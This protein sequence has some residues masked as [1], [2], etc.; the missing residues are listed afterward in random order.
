M[1]GKIGVMADSS[2]D[3]PVG[4]AKKK[5]INLVPNSIFINKQ[6]PKL[7]GVDIENKE[8]LEYLRQKDDVTTEA[9]V[10]PR[11]CLMFQTLLKKYEYLYSFNV[12]DDLSKCYENAQYGLNLYKQISLDGDTENKIKLIDTRAVGISF[13]IIVNRI[14]TIVNVKQDMEIARL[15]KYIAW[16]VKN[17]HMYFVVDDL[18]WLKRSGKLNMISG[19]LGQLLDFKPVI[20]LEKGMLLP[21]EKCRGK[22]IAVDG[23]IKFIKEAASKYKRG[24]EIW[25]GHSAAI[26]D[27]KYAVKQLAA[28]LK[29][30]KKKILLVDIGPTMAAHIGPGGVCVTMLPR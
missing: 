8:V 23:M 25:V 9:V 1:V 29:I 5:Q 27:A 17:L 20:K 30:D 24:F 15:D 11:F 3:L 6:G 22:N 7:H 2:A 14:A 18:Y 4:F 10:P 12:S 28:S 19:F 16:L 26:L 21:V 13:G